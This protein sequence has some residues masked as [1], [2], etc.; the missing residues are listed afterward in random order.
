MKYHPSNI[1]LL[2]NGTKLLSGILP[3]HPVL[4]LNFTV[5]SRRLL[6]NPTCYL[7]H[8]TMLT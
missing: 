4:S 7:L 3:Y 1:H 5:D 8:I 2:R 6:Q